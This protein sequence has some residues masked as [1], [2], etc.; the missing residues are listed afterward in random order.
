MPIHGD[1]DGPAY[2]VT[3]PYGRICGRLTWLPLLGVWLGLVEGPGDCTRTIESTDVN[4][5]RTWM[6]TEVQA[7]RRPRR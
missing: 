4:V 6:V 7:L 3:H 5:V 1:E 2:L